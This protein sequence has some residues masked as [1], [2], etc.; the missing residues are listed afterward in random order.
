MEKNLNIIPAVLHINEASD[1]LKY[2]VPDVSTL[3]LQLSKELLNTFKIDNADLLS[4]ESDLSAI[5]Q[6][7]EQ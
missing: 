4:T 7:N 5:S 1:L 3:L 2:E 6:T